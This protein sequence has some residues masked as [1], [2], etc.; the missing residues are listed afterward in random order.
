MSVSVHAERP[1]VPVEHVLR[2]SICS[3]SHLPVA[4]STSLSLSPQRSQGGEGGFTGNCSGSLTTPCLS[5]FYSYLCLLTFHKM[6]GAEFDF[7]ADVC[8]RAYPSLSS[9]LVAIRNQ[10][11]AQ[12][13]QKINVLSAEGCSDLDC[14][15]SVLYCTCLMFITAT[16][17]LLTCYVNSPNLLR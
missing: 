16:L 2:L 13:R 9:I 3:S 4:L 8:V 6:H 10:T 1:Y 14:H 17:I 15:L 11:L 5:C 12:G 7:P